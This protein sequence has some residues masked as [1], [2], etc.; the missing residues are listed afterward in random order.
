MNMGPERSLHVG[1]SCFIGLKQAQVSDP[2]AF[3]HLL[4]GDFDAGMDF[5]GVHPWWNRG[6]SE[7]NGLR[8]LAYEQNTRHLRLANQDL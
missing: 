6:V 1:S 2:S 5:L 3:G 4:Q 8:S 7:I